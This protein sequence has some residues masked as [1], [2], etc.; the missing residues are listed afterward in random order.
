MFQRLTSLFFSDS[1]T[2]EGLEEPKPFVEEEEEEDGWL[3]IDLA[4][5]NPLL[6]QA[7]LVSQRCGS[8]CPSR[9]VSMSERGFWPRR[10]AGPRVAACWRGARPRQCGE[11]P[12][13]GPAHRA[14]QHVRLRHQHPRGGWGGPRGRCCRG[15]CGAAAGAA[16]GAAR[17]GA[18][19]E[20]GGAGQGGAGAA[21]AAGQA[22]GGAAAPGPEGAAAA[23]QGPA[24]PAPPCQAA[25]GGLRPPA[26]PA[27]LQLL[28]S[29]RRPGAPPGRPRPRDRPSRT[30]GT[31]RR[32]HS[33]PRART[34][35]PHSSSSSCTLTVPLT[36]DAVWVTIPRS[37][38]HGGPCYPS[39]AASAAFTREIRIPPEITSS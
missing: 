21:G 16:R 24:A 39:P 4:G 7:L 11:Q 9:A 14:P 34:P 22:A 33:T 32:L 27:P 36:L 5:K 38:R 12:H 13:G 18:G 10:G 26:Q 29:L 25:P 31:R 8:A 20:G 6:Q 17:P 19:G 15:R 3:I 30:P 23:E 35:D 2:P 1:N 37:R 28:T